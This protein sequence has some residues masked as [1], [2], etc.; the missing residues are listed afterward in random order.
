M[1]ERASSM[2]TDVA[3]CPKLPAVGTTCRVEVHTSKAKP[4]QFTN[5]MQRKTS[6]LPVSAEVELQ[7]CSDTRE[8]VPPFPFDDDM[9][10]AYIQRSNHDVGVTKDPFIRKMSRRLCFVL[11]WGAPSLHRPILKDGYVLVKDLRAIS[12]FSQNTDEMVRQI[13]CNDTKRHFGLQE[14]KD[15][16]LRV[17]ANHGHGIPGVEVVERDFT[18]QDA[19][20]YAVHV[21]S[22]YAWSLIQFKGLK[23]GKRKHIH[24]I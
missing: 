20:G 18:L 12:A 24:F 22:Y 9:L 21:T 3:D 6:T 13:V 16:S 23:C 2:P 1:V 7:E 11:R 17:R 15:G 4:E 5:V 19:V 14:T 8:D 10:D